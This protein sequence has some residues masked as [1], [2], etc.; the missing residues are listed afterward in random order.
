MTRALCMMSTIHR[1]DDDR[2][3]FKQARSLANRFPGVKV[4]SP[5]NGFTGHLSNVEW[6]TIP[7]RG[8]MLGRLINIADLVRSAKAMD[9]EVCHLHDLDLLLAV[10]ALRLL[11]RAKVVYDSHEAYPDVIRLSQRIPRSLRPMASVLVNWVEKRLARGCDLIITPTKQVSESFENTGVPIETV[12]NYPRL[13]AH[14]SG[15]RACSGAQDEV[16]GSLH[17]AVSGKRQ[18]RARP[19]PHARRHGAAA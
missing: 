15:S 19:R 5:A 13:E 11:T 14:P 18:P 2:I 17:A 4:L 6:V 7:Q 3:Y 16:P 1:P 10:P 8:G 9:A 12:F